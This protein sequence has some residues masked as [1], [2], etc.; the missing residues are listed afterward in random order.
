MTTK[1]TSLTA[2]RQ[3]KELTVVWDDGHTS[4]YPFSLLR[5]GCPCA[6]CRGGHDKMSDEPVP[7]I[8]DMHLPDSPAT[9]QKNILPV[10]LYAIT[11][12]WEDGHDYGIFDW[13]IT[14]GRCARARSVEVLAVETAPVTAFSSACR[15]ASVSSWGSLSSA[16]W[17]AS[18]FA[19]PFV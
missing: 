14:C 11:P 6:E 10:G 17:L 3:T 19:S 7:E 2:N 9:R 8:F 4:V 13:H 16:C 1:P 15:W 18:A 12:V 5:A